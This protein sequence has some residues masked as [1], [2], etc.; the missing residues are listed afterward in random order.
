MHVRDAAIMVSRKRATLLT[1][2][3]LTGIAAII[4]S[5]A[6]LSNVFVHSLSDVQ[7]DSTQKLAA[8]TYKKEEEHTHLQTEVDNDGQDN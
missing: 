2:G 8:Y 6:Q 3:T 1:A 7:K 5:V 4:A